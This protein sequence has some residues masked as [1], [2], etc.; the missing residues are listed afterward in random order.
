M[1]DCATKRIWL[2]QAENALHE[3]MTGSKTVKAT[4]GP[5]KGVEYSQANIRELQAYI[6]QLR[7]EVAECDG[8][9]VG[10]RGPVRFSF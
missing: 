9:S 6:A 4:F 1:T 3:I 5:S 10:K 8:N 2:A 7:A